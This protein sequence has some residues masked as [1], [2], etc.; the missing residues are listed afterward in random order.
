[1]SDLLLVLLK[2]KRK[3]E[4]IMDNSPTTPNMNKTP[5]GL[6]SS[7]ITSFGSF[8]IP[9]PILKTKGRALRAQLVLYI[10]EIV[11]T[12][13]AVLGEWFIISL[14]NHETTQEFFMTST[15]SSQSKD[16]NKP[17]DIVKVYIVPLTAQMC[18]YASIG[19][20]SI[21]FLLTLIATYSTKVPKQYTKYLY[22]ICV[23]FAITLFFL[24]IATHAGFEA[25]VGQIVTV[26]SLTGSL[27]GV[28]YS[29]RGYGY[30]ALIISWMLA[31]PLFI[32]SNAVFFGHLRGA[33]ESHWRDTLRASWGQGIPDWLRDTVNGSSVSPTAKDSP[34]MKIDTPLSLAPKANI[35][36]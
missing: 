29:G 9:K 33:W 24:Q 26:V 4:K 22:G 12:V 27:K 20:A 11:F 34:V 10:L 7:S 15:L 35:E 18:A 13:S 19:I 17:N 32:V 3:R 1:M 6:A 5:R 2:G 30:A 31:I 21:G 23:L 16:P 8:M 28:D 36:I 25:N 14:Q